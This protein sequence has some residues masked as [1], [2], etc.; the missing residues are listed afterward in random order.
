MEVL[1]MRSPVLPLVLFAI[2]PLA[3]CGNADDDAF[4]GAAGADSASASGTSGAG[5]SATS[6]SGGGSSS[7]SSTSAS[8]GESCPGAGDACTTCESAKCVAEYCICSQNPSCVKLA[9][10]DIPCAP[11]DLACHQACWTANPEGISAGALLVDCASK[12]CAEGCP[13]LTGLTP[14]QKCLYQECPAAMN[15]CI[16][17]AECTNLLYCLAACTDATCQNGCATAHPGGIEDAGPV[18]ACA[19]QRCAA[20]CS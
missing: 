19:Q 3:A 4:G 16:A 6:G 13:G 14:C 15:P 10:C 2:V 7:T 17:N 20:T 1:L 8:S 9:Q 11:G 18:S 12:S 5:T